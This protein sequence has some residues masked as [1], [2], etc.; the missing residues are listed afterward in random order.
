MSIDHVLKL[1]SKTIQSSYLHYG[2]WDDPESIAI[3]SINLEEIKNA[4]ARYIEN[5]ASY[6][7]NQVDLILDVGC[8]IGGNAEFLIN[9]GYKVETLSPDDF[10]KEAINEKFN[11]GVNFHHCKFEKFQPNKKYDLV[12]ESESAC[13]ININKGFEKAREALCKSGYLLASDYFIHFRD[14]SKSPHLRSSHDMDKY[15]NGAKKYGF[16]LLEKYD[17]TENTM[18]TLDYGKYFFERFIDPTID[19]A[20]YSLQKNYPKTASVIEKLIKPKIVAKKEQLDLLDSGLFRRYRK[21]M[22]YLFQKK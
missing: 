18:P 4:Q 14:G 3:D 8:G 22:I 2:F 11:G 6:I 10:Q 15:L 19:Y 13:Y 21:Y 5:L 12:L 7:P 20:S 1:Y 16:E 17:Q 9:R